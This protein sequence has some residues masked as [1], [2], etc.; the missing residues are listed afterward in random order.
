M[1]AEKHYQFEKFTLQKDHGLAGIGLGLRLLLAFIEVRGTGLALRSVD[2][3]A[4]NFD[5][6]TCSFLFISG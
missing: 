1:G 6:S 2:N 4:S 5:F 3:A